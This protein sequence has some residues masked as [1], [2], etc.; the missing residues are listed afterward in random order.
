[1]IYR[2]IYWYCEK[3]VV[4]PW[5]GNNVLMCRGRLFLGP[6][7]Y[8]VILSF[9]LITLPYGIFIAFPVNVILLL[10]H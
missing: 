5:P 4:T 6:A 7:Y 2:A 3:K 1:M 10:K 9:L 8:A